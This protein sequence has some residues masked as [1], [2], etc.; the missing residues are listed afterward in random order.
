MT[1]NYEWIDNPTVAG[2]SAYNPDVLNDCLMHLK[3][4]VGETLQENISGCSDTNLSNVLP[5][6][7]STIAN[8]AMPSN[9][10]DSLSIGSSGTAYTAPAN[11]WFSFRMYC[12]KSPAF[13]G[14]FYPETDPNTESWFATSKW[15]NQADTNVTLFI[16][17]K[18]GQ[19]VLI[20]YKNASVKSGSSFLNFVYSEGDATEE[21][22][23]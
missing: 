11:G 21:G 2:V 14:L 22:E 7:K 20:S 5:E 3:Y 1:N 6:G 12:A 9:K 18:K 10:Y 4:D 19:Q 15:V 13:V 17:A 8:F 16:P 23:E